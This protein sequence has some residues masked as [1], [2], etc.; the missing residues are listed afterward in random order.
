MIIYKL[1]DNTNDNYYIGSTINFENRKISHNYHKQYEKW[2]SHNIIKNNDY[3]FEILEEDEITD[4]KHKIMREQ[5]YLDKY[6]KD[7]KCINVINSY[8]GL[9][10]KEYNRQHSLKRSRWIRS[11][12]DERKTCCL[13]RISMDIFN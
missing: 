5:Y 9:T 3:R 7:T 6:M 2:A 13:W 10:K 12:G 11:W 4:H 1:I 8:S